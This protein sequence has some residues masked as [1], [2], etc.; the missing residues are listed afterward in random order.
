MLIPTCNGYAYERIL[1][2]REI[3]GWWIGGGGGNLLQ[4]KTQMKESSYR[5]DYDKSYGEKIIEAIN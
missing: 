1:H 5:T 4:T 2:L 3:D